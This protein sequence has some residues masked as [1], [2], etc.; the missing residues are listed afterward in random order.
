MRPPRILAILVL[1]SVLMLRTLPVVAAP[2]VTADAAVLMDWK[3]GT[4][5]YEKNAH[6]IRHPASLTKMLTAVV[7]LEHANLQDVVVVP[8]E[9]CSV[10][11]SSAGLRKGQRY[12]MEDLL[13]MLLLKSANDAACAIAIH[14][15][16]SI[17][18][19]ARLMNDKARQ[20]GAYNT[21]FLNP[22]GL[23]EPGHLTTA[24]DQALI[25]RYALSIPFFA[26]TVSTKE[27][28]VD[29]LDRDVVIRLRNTNKLLWYFAGMDGVKTGTTH[30]AGKSLAASAT[31]DG[32]RLVT[33]VLHSD[34][35]WND[36]ANLLEY[37]FA[38]FELVNP[39]NKGDIVRTVRVRGGMEPRVPIIATSDLAAV[40]PKTLRERLTVLEPCRT[41]NAPC[42]PSRSLCQVSLV[43]D[44]KVLATTD[45]R[46]AREVKRY[47]I[48][49]VLYVR[50][51][52]PLIR[53]FLRLQ[54]S[55]FTT[56]DNPRAMWKDRWRT[57]V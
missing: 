22:H 37:G 52:V 31:R 45:V 41:V 21:T 17:P 23:T 4:V 33:V 25:A 27:A 39:Y 35:R 34:A 30:A 26:E 13:Y 57:R 43:L 3:T 20:I 50:L 55:G 1:V 56:K 18:E 42:D 12:T 11:G 38:A 24:Y 51:F 46:P 8:E 10:H 36:A 49:R 54:T 28:E 6:S 19:F 15:A 44:G 9:A 2:R 48:W 5:L 32:Q 53:W 7:A 14:V 40:V 16:G 47:S 29:R